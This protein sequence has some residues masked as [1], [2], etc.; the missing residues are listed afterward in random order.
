[1]ILVPTNQKENEM[2]FDT[3]WPL[4]QSAGLSGLTVALVVLVLVFIADYTNLLKNGDAKRVAVFILSILFANVP[5]GGV[6]N[7]TVG[8]IGAI[9]ASLLK[10]LLDMLIAVAKQQKMAMAEKK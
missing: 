9:G 7:A 5:A 6:F 2:S 1:L 4:I 10:L 8:A 3:L